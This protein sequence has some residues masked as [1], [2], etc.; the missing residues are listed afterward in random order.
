MYMKRLLYK[1]QSYHKLF[2]IEKILK[3]KLKNKHSH[4]LKT[5]IIIKFLLK[6]SVYSRMK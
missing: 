6:E 4:T 2:N 3:F 1:L 5:I